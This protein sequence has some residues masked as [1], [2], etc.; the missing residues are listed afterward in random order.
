[1]RQGAGNLNAA[2]RCCIRSLANL[3]RAT[4]AAAAIL[5]LVVGIAEAEGR[6]AVSYQKEPVHFVPGTEDIPLMPGLAALTDRGFIFDKA[7]GRILAVSAAG[8]VTR[9]AVLA[10]YQESLPELGW[11]SRGPNRFVRDGENLA[12]VINGTD[13]H[14]IVNFSL[15]AQ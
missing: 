4:A 14:L 10:F 3:A 12:L 5:C 13:G 1:M 6:L 15:I 7:D 8:A 11:Q 9:R 2:Y